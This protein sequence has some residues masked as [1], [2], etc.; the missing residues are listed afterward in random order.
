LK[1]TRGRVTGALSTARDIT[2]FRRMREALKESE[3]LYRH[4]VETSQDLIWQ[5]D[6]EG[7]Y[8]YLNPAWEELF[9]Y[10]VEEMLGRRFSEFQSPKYAERDTKEFARLMEGESVRGYE[11]VHLG[12]DGR[13]IHLVLNA[14][15]LRDQE[16][17]IAGIRGTAHDVTERRRAE[18]LLREKEQQLSL[19]FDNVS[20][21]LFYLAVEADD[22]FRF[23]SVNKVF[24]QATSLSEDQIIGKEV[25]EV[26]REPAHELVL[27]KYHEAIH[28]GRT[29][30]WEEISVYPSGKKYGEVSVTPVFDAAGHCTHLVGTVHDATEHRIAQE[31]IRASEEKYRAYFDNS[32]D[33]ILLTS[34][35]GSIEAANPAACQMLERTEAE[36]IQAGRAGLVDTSDPRLARLLAERARTGKARGELTLLRRDGMP[37]PAEI[38]S[39]VF[40]DSDG[41]A[42]TSMIVRDIT[43]RKQ[44][45]EELRQR[46]EQLTALN[47][48]AREIARTLSLEQRATAA[49]S[50]TV[51]TIQPDAA[52]IFVRDGENLN[53]AGLGPQGVQVKFGEMPEHRVGACICGLAVKEGKSLY[54]RNIFEDN[55]CTWE[56]CKKAGLRSFAALPLRIADETIGVIRIGVRAGTRF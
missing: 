5:C 39:A 32:M 6:A 30:T 50:E 45:E 13:E 35:D 44:A 29:A 42:R 15:S 37:F 7:R 33:A 9:G 22:R 19:I 40:Q 27:G 8:S 47:T 49:I 1:D 17:N 10:K 56:E 23:V 41:N 20:D 12:K 51:R 18:Q 31:R 26:I 2:D 34:P 36:I 24:L 11:T 3:A 46:A 21:V 28:Q 16:G 38:S 48:L 55:R 52:F 53:L 14:R 43:E 54:S 25:R 4:L